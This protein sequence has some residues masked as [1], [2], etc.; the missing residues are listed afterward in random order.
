MV[1]DSS[2]Q[3]RTQLE[4]ELAGQR[5]VTNAIPTPQKPTGLATILAISPERLGA[6]KMTEGSE[7]A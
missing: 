4:L 7:N 6:V 3:T 1:F 2:R 5:S